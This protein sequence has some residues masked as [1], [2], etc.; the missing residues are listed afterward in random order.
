MQEEKA[1]LATVV[2]NSWRFL[3]GKFFGFF[4]MVEPMGFEP[5]TSSMPSRRA[6]NCATA[7]PPKL[8][9]VYHNHLCSDLPPNRF[10][11]GFQPRSA[12]AN[13]PDSVCYSSVKFPIFHPHQLKIFCPFPLANFLVTRLIIRTYL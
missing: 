12:S 7:P 6:P 5:T 8:F 1:K 10:S 9:S 11:P 4:R 13:G 3:D 2:G